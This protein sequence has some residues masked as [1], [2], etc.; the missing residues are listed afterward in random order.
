MNESRSAGTLAASAEL[1][2]EP[3]RTRNATT[4]MLDAAS[5]GVREA[6]VPR[7]TSTAPATASTSCP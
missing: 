5:S 2:T 7:H 4:S 6:S 3:K 1:T